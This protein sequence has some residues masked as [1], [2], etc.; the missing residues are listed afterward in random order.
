MD[1][2]PPPT[3]E[4]DVT[5]ALWTVPGLGS[6]T[7]SGVRRWASGRWGDLLATPVEEWVEEMP[8]LAEPV[9]QR[10]LELG[11]LRD[12]AAQ[13]RE[14]AAA[15]DMEVLSPGDAG[16]PALLAEVRDAPPI[17][18]F[19]GTVSPS[20]R[21]LALVGTRHPEQG[22]L[23]RAREFA[24]VVALRGA[25]VVSGAAAGVDRSCHLG[26]LDVGGESWAFLGSALDAID[27]A[28]ERLVPAILDAGGAV[29]SELP[30]GVRASPQTFPRRNRLISGASDAV[31]VLRAGEASGALYTVR[32]AQEQGRPIL[33][34]PGEV[35]AE[36]AR[37]CNGL[38]AAGVAAPCLSAEDALRAIGLTTPPPPPVR[39][40]TEALSERARQVYGLLSRTP[41]ALEE[42]EG[43]SGLQP[44]A[45]VSALCELELLGLAIQ[46]P[47]R[48]YE[49]V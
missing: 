16:Y 39:P 9:R 42:L 18:F 33:A 20:R 25:G 36:T 49:Q 19:R 11:S 29:Y 31:V 14:A 34:W 12:V 5:L 30:P 15:G 4:R 2:T 1:A 40:D 32:A 38:I 47:G 17:L 44:G 43:A 10:L 48:R 24:S 21:R 37:G 7:L 35:W 3:A 6:M 22:F 8:G 27:P 26:A 45:L 13:A 41:R 23:R 28:Q 46:S